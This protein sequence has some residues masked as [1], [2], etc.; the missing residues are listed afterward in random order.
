MQ[1]S[2]QR[3]YNVVLNSFKINENYNA[4]LVINLNKYLSDVCDFSCCVL[5]HLSHLMPL[6]SFYIT[7][8]H[9]KTF[10]FL[11]FSGGIEKDQWHEMD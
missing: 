11:V 2:Q 4:D 6:I 5:S 9:K 1:L 3:Q 10:S 7:W 8:K